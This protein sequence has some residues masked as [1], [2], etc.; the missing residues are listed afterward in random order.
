[1]I[2]PKN[3]GQVKPIDETSPSPGDEAS[4]GQGAFPPLE[5]RVFVYKYDGSKQCG[6]GQP[7]SVK[8]MAK[9][10]KGMQVFSQENKPDGLMHIQVCGAATG[11]ANVY[12]IKAEDLAKAQAKGFQEWK[13]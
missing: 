10:L 13:F 2:T 7:I 4:A 6:A 1:M 11:R 12:E 5:N 3:P 9:E 8:T